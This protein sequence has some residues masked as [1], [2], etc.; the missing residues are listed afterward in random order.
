MAIHVTNFTISLGLAP[1]VSL[2]SSKRKR[3][4]Q[5]VPHELVDPFGSKSVFQTIQY[6]DNEILAFHIMKMRSC[7]RN[8]V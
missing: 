1:E 5:R 2:A 4:K 8:N 3:R 7:H 6:D